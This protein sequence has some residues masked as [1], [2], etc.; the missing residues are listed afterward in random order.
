MIVPRENFTR[1]HTGTRRMRQNEIV[2]SVKLSTDVILP[3]GKSPQVVYAKRLVL[4]FH[5]TSDTG[6][7]HPV[8]R[9]EGK[10]EYPAIVWRQ[11]G[12]QLIG[13]RLAPFRIEKTWLSAKHGKW[14]EGAECYSYRRPD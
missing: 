7:D 11:V 6:N 12:N 10:M 8:G 5:P 3:E 13:F 14:Q 9:V 4:V 1:R 2:Y